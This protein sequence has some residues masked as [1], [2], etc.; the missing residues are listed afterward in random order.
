MPDF[1]RNPPSPSPVIIARPPS[2]LVC[3]EPLALRRRSS[4]VPGRE[5]KQAPAPAPIGAN[6]VGAI[7]EAPPL[8]PPS[9]RR[10]LLPGKF[11][12]PRLRSL[13]DGIFRNVIN[14]K[15]HANGNDND[16]DRAWYAVVRLGLNGTLYHEVEVETVLVDQP[17]KLVMGIKGEGHVVELLHSR[18]REMFAADFAQGVV[19]PSVQ[20]RPGYQGVLFEPQ[21]IAGS[22]AK[23]QPA[24]DQAREAKLDKAKSDWSAEIAR[25]LPQAAQSQLSQHAMKQQLQLPQHRA[26]FDLLCAEKDKVDDGKRN[27]A[28][29]V[30][31]QKLALPAVS[32]YKPSPPVGAVRHSLTNLK[33]NGAV[34]KYEGAWRNPGHVMFNLQDITLRDNSIANQKLVYYEASITNI[35]S[36]N[37]GLCAFGLVLSKVASASKMPGQLAHSVGLHSNSGTVFLEND[38]VKLFSRRLRSGDVV[39]CGLLRHSRMAFFTLNGRFM[40]VPGLIKPEFSQSAVAHISLFS[41]DACVR[42]NFGNEPFAFSRLPLLLGNKNNVPAVISPKAQAPAPAPQ[43]RPKGKQKQ[44]KVK[45]APKGRPDLQVHHIRRGRRNQVNRAGLVHINS[46]SD[47]DSSSS[48]SEEEQSEEEEEGDHGEDVDDNDGEDEEGQEQKNE[49]VVVAEEAEAEAEWSCGACTYLN[50]PLFLACEICATQRPP[51]PKKQAP[52]PAQAPGQAKLPQAQIEEVDSDSDDGEEQNEPK[53]VEGLKDEHKNEEKEDEKEKEKEDEKEEKEKKK[54][55]VECDDEESDEWSDGEVRVEPVNVKIGSFKMNFDG[56]SESKIEGKESKESKMESKEDKAQLPK[57]LVVSSIDRLEIQHNLV[58]EPRGSL[59][60]YSIVFDLQVP[61]PGLAKYHLVKNLVVMPNGRLSFH[62]HEHNGP[63]V[64]AGRWHRVAMTVNLPELRVTIY[65]DGTFQRQLRRN[66]YGDIV[67]NMTLGDTLSMFQQPNPRK[68]VRSIQLFARELQPLEVYQMGT[69][70]GP[71]PMFRHVTDIKADLKLISRSLIRIGNALYG[72]GGASSPMYRLHMDRYLQR[73]QKTKGEHKGLDEEVYEKL[74][75][76][77]DF[78]HTPLVEYKGDI[79]FYGGQRPQHGASNELRRLDWDSMQFKVVPP[80][81]ECKHRPPALYGHATAVMGNYLYIYG[82]L[83]LDRTRMWR[84]GLLSGVW[85]E[86]HFID[87]IMPD[88]QVGG[89]LVAY[90]GWLF[91]LGA[92][93]VLNAAAANPI[94]RLWIDDTDPSRLVGLFVRNAAPYIQPRTNASYVLHG[95]HIYVVGGLA[96]ANQVVRYSLLD[97]AWSYLVGPHAPA[98]RAASAVGFFGETLVIAGG[99]DGINGGLVA[100]DNVMALDVTMADSL[101]FLE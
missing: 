20:M 21:D 41:A 35:G 14:D 71:L 1:L 75:T 82:G 61:H 5:N 53:P 31:E 24:L 91:F 68:L 2:P 38:E 81:P 36:S 77:C 51:K 55:A 49:A 27:D 90:Q 48:L 33:M 97:A 100:R 19:P 59:R 26:E 64:E 74:P 29:L 87:S 94:F 70:R 73:E 13:L 12:D 50:K 42:L 6:P 28:A 40:G 30:V 63:M 15:D 3:L 98:S 37:Y 17:L 88:A 56:S 62:N 84:Y 57:A 23:R 46:D 86:I 16:A 25:R 92:S 85:E 47:S 67:N 79:Y 32:H 66:P 80:A 34:V 18:A 52:S 69:C 78:N 60:T 54:V 72:L 44:K 95:D 45:F 22:E 101:F 65:C 8:T 9:Q 96:H 93:S 43:A 99:N 89:T 58:V 4:S 11:D 7:P 83:P 39:G 76:E 10:L